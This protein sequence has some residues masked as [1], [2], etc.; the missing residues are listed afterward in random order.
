VPRHLFCGDDATYQ[1]VCQMSKADRQEA[2]NHLLGHCAHAIAVPGCDYE[3]GLIYDPSTNS[4]TPI[5]DWYD[6]RLA[7]IL[8]PDHS[9]NPLLQ[10]YAVEVTRKQAVANG[11]AVTHHGVDQDGTIDLVLTSYVV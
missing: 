8:P 6:S 11:Y 9:K 5:W 3:I 1:A 10:Q 7:Q 2:M 4:Y